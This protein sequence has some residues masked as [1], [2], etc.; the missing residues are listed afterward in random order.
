[1][2][3][4]SQNQV[5]RAKSRVSICLLLALILGCNEKGKEK[6]KS[7]SESL[8]STNKSGEQSVFYAYETNDTIRMDSALFDDYTLRI[9]S[10]SLNDSGIVWSEDDT[11]GM[12]INNITHYL[13]NATLQIE[14]WSKGNKINEV[15]YSKLDFSTTLGKYRMSFCDR[16]YPDIAI[17]NEEN[18]YAVINIMTCM[19]ETDDC[20]DGFLKI[21]IP[22]LTTV[23]M[24][25]HGG[26]WCSSD[27]SVFEN[28]NMLTCHG[29]HNQHGKVLLDITENYIVAAEKI[30]KEHF[31]II[32]DLVDH[33]LVEDENGNERWQS[34]EDDST[35]NAHIYNLEG[36]KLSTFRYDGY[37][38]PMGY[39][40]PLIKLSD[41]CLVL[42]DLESMEASKITNHQ[43]D[44]FELMDYTDEELIGFDQYR[45][46]TV[47]GDFSI[48]TNGKD[49]FKK[50]ENS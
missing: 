26:M 21:R 39:E 6:G 40:T 14:L 41:S 31:I 42:F 3:S 8:A 24:G 29:L 25:M 2:N 35:D 7:D 9:L 36:R 20:D 32:H 23:T 11:N 50:L 22:E 15:K 1:M 38:E 46:H 4:S 30:G 49:F 16:V 27:I 45:V 13:H 18:G 47:I 10:Y 33:K 28:G 19:P 48:Y 37:L 44:R 12:R 17:V 5:Q 43:L 34:F